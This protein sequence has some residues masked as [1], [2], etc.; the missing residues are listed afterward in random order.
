MK[1]DIINEF[2]NKITCTMLFCFKNETN[3]YVVYTNGH[4]TNGKLDVYAS[5]YNIVDKQYVLT[6]I[7]DDAEWNL[8][9]QHLASYLS[10]A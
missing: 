2:G 7:N 9:D 8:V 1:F 6:N 4:R 5:R 3:Q 10:E